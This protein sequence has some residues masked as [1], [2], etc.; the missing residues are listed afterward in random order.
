MS[1]LAAEAPE[2]LSSTQAPLL[3]ESAV[4][5]GNTRPLQDTSPGAPGCLGTYLGRPCMHHTLCPG[6]VR[7]GHSHPAHPFHRL[8]SDHHAGLGLL[9][10][11]MKINPGHLSRG[12]GSI[13]EALSLLSNAKDAEKRHRVMG[14]KAPGPRLEASPQKVRSQACW[15]QAGPMRPL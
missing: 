6:R 11:F 12:Q 3:L 15:G 8:I 7:P 2:R 10:S 13:N 1:S 4:F 5:P 14:D 9:L